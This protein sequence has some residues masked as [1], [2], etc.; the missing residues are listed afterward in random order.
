MCLLG[1]GAARA[2]DPLSLA[3][4]TMGFPDASRQVASGSATPPPFGFRS[5]P[6]DW[7]CSDIGTPSTERKGQKKM[8]GLAKGE[9]PAKSEQN[10]R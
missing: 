6:L 10:L 7:W 1:T 4:E 3:E 2:A 9:S 5:W 8:V